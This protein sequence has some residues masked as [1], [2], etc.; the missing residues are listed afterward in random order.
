MARRS[1]GERNSARRAKRRRER[2]VPS[3][4]VGGIWN[5]FPI[6]RV[7]PRQMAR[8]KEMVRAYWLRN[9]MAGHR[10]TAVGLGARWGTIP[11]ETANPKAWRLYAANRRALERLLAKYPEVRRDDA[12]HMRELMSNYERTGIAASEGSALKTYIDV[13]PVSPNTLRALKAARR[14]TGIRPHRA[15]H[16]LAT[17]H[18]G[19]CDEAC[20]SGLRTHYHRVERG[21]GLPYG[22]V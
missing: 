11:T 6:R 21:V 4:M 1:R 2:Q 22:P 13:P 18:I 3:G 20:R 5:P 15:R 9:T 12:R 17:H 16:T 19:P 10:N 14:T 8:T 7:P